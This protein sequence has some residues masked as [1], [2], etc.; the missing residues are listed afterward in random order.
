MWDQIWI[1]W[2]HLPSLNCGSFYGFVTLK[3]YIIISVY[4]SSLFTSAAAVAAAA[5]G[6]QKKLNDRAMH[7][8]CMGVRGFV[9]AVVDVVSIIIAPLCSTAAHHVRDLIWTLVLVV[10]VD[11]APP[12]TI[13]LCRHRRRCR[14]EKSGAASCARPPR[15]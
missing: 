1:Q 7:G 4:L 14:R 9:A 5:G 10:V 13:F 6:A 3:Y 2:T 12:S 11:A 8:P 15:Y